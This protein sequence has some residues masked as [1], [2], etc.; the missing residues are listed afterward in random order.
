MTPS[1]HLLLDALAPRPSDGPAPL[2]ARESGDRTPAAPE[3]RVPHP[4][5]APLTSEPPLAVAAPLTSESPYPGALPLTSE[6]AA[7]ATGQDPSVV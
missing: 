4:A 3:G 2:V 6:P 7:Q 1:A 5:S